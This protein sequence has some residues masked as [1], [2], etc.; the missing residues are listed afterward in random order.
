[1]KNKKSLVAVGVDNQCA[2]VINEEK[3][4]VVKSNQ[5]AK[6]FKMFYDGGEFDMKNLEDFGKVDDLTTK[7]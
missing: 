3:F 7:Q 6:V 4:E 2:L 5:E 1:M